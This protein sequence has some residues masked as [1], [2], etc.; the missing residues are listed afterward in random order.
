MADIKVDK[1]SIQAILAGS[2]SDFLIPDY[3]RPYSWEMDQCK[4]LWDDILEF[5]IPEND[6]SRFRSD[7]D[8]YFLGSIVTF[9]NSDGK[10]EII[11]GQQRLTTILLML[12]AFYDKFLHAQDP[13]T[14]STRTIIERCIWK[15]NEYEQP[16]KENLK[17]TSDVASDDDKEEFLSILKTGK[18]SKESKSTYA[19]NY[20]FFCEAIDNFSRDFPTYTNL[21]AIRMLKYCIIMPIEASDEDTAIRIFSTL[22]NRGL[23]L[24][25][26]DIFKSHLYKFYKTKGEEEK[27]RF[28][29]RWKAL[30]ETANSIFN[31][32]TGTPM[33]ELFAN[34]MYYLRAKKGIT[35][36]TTQS[37]RDFYEH[38]GNRKSQQNVE[39]KFK[40]FRDAETMDNLEKIAFFWN[41]VDSQDATFFTSEIL[42]KLYVLNY[43][44][45]NTWKYLLSVYFM[46]NSDSPEIFKSKEFEIFLEKT[47]LFTIAYGIYRPGVGLLR[48]PIFKAMAK[49]VKH[50]SE[51]FEKIGIKETGVDINSLLESY[52]FWNGRPITKS[53]L[54]WYAFTF[55]NQNLPKLEESFQI[56]HIFAKNRS[57]YENTKIDEAIIESIGNKVLLEKR[58]NIRASDYRFEDKRENFYKNNSQ[59]AEITELSKFKKFDKD[60]IIARKNKIFETFSDSLKN[61]KLI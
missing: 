37:L 14:V 39:S 48:S 27:S 26:A 43:S 22:N 29:H 24:S 20:R 58:I 44:P 17:I 16:D 46:A 28:V 53:I 32:S 3:Q 61:H 2:N 50:D 19:K 21:P 59:I 42:R 55:E 4:T 18:V 30:E 7:K 1:K 31:S 9:K 11:D 15:T 5:S 60:E 6:E 34:Y 23:P 8:E 41:R 13:N 12:R 57:L 56:E 54:T 49:I 38:N 36:T 52:E 47:S 33:D 45:N 40:F 35:D 10:L 51:I 25:D